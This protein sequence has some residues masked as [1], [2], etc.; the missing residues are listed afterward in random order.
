MQH[1]P[2]KKNSKE[3]ICYGKKETDFWLQVSVKMSVLEA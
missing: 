2:L 1:L 3:E